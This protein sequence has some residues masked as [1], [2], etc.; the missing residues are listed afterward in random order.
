MFWL[1]LIDEGAMQQTTRQ[2][3]PMAA[4]EL[5]QEAL[6]LYRENVT[7]FLGIVL[8]P[9]LVETVLNLLIVAGSSGGSGSVILSILTSVVTVALS[10]LSAGALSVAVASRYLGRAVTV[11]QAYSSIGADMLWILFLASLLGG[12]IV[13]IGFVLLVIPGIY[14]LVRFIFVPQVV[15]LERT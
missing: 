1:W 8:I 2:L 14:L 5:L 6:E 7:L 13:G 12:L 15:V 9:I 4:G 11:G 3:R 10:L